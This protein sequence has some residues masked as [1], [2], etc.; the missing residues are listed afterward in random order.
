MKLHGWT[1][2]RTSAPVEYE[3]EDLAKEFL[4]SRFYDPELPIDRPLRNFLAS[5]AE[6][7]GK[8]LAWD[9]RDVASIE[10]FDALYDRIVD[11]EEEISKAKS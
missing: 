2:N 4:A 5:T 3:I 6:Q 1:G 10:A 9:P 8:D 7:G 11:L